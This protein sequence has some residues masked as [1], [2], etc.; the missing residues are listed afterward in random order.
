MKYMIRERYTC[1]RGKAPEYLESLKVVVG[2]M[3]V[4]EIEFHKLMVDVPGPMDTVH[5]E[6]EVYDIQQ[7]C[8]FERGFY[9][10]LDTDTQK[11]ID[12]VN[13]ITVSANR[14]IFI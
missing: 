6:F 10:N 11:L 3:Q 9:E 12:H 5:H 7:Y 13:S 4:G 2:F 14:E 1:Q 8:A